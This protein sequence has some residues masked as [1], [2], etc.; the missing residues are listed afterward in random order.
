MTQT[1]EEALEVLSDSV[2]AYIAEAELDPLYCGVTIDE[3]RD[4]AGKLMAIRLVFCDQMFGH[5]VR[6]FDAEQSQCPL[7]K[8]QD[9]PLIIA[10]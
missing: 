4:S 7:V 5:Q 2:A 9:K 8:V 6:R 10:S 3:M 1:R